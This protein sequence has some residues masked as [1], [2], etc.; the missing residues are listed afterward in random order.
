MRRRELIVCL[1]LIELL[2]PVSARAQ[3]K[4]VRI[5]YIGRRSTAL[6]AAS[7]D[8]F[9]EELRGHGFLPGRNL[10]I[11]VRASDQD[12]AALSRD[13]RDLI[14]A[15]A[16]LL[17]AQGTEEVLRAAMAASAVVPIVMIATNFDP[18]A[19][20]YVKGLSHPGG[21]VTGVFLRQPEL[22]KK[23][24]ELLTLTVP[25]KSRM[26][27]LW[28]EISAEQ[29]AAAEAQAKDLG[30][31]VSS[32]KLLQPPYDFEDAF[33][34]LAE[35]S[36]E[37]LVVLSSPHFTRSRTQIAQLAI[38][39]GW[40]AMF[41]FRTYV[42][43]GGLISYGA[44]YPAMHRQAARIAARILSGTSPSDLP[45]EQPT[46]FELVISLKTARALDLTVPQSLLAR[47]D[48]VIE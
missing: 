44:N 5:G 7:Y 1:S 45:V 19:R 4:V 23:Q 33:R 48:E 25:G 46:T 9:V 41:I 11:E 22:A 21:N 47:A 6:A 10:A 37:L 8:S 30:L 42:D 43:A 34:H 32:L 18:I 17:V 40:P 35:A 31:Q 14:A 28:D 16:D 38:R 24:V 36:P 27:L 15:N 26:A 29:F 3:S 39:H 2:R 13:A 20:G 12:F